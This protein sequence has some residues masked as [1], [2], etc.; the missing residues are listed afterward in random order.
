MQGIRARKITPPIKSPLNKPVDWRHSSAKNDLTR[1]LKDPMSSLRTMSVQNIHSSDPKYSCYD[2][3]NFSRSVKRLAK[4]VGVTLPVNKK[5]SSEKPKRNEDGP[6]WRGSNEQLLLRKILRDTKSSLRKQTPE[7]IY[8]LHAG[9]QKW[10]FKAFKKN[11]RSLKVAV[12]AEIKSL[13]FEE[14]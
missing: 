2:F 5:K 14:E 10:E 11:C 6:S 3:E 4:K 12:C 1:E 8:N 13:K 9:F 7:D